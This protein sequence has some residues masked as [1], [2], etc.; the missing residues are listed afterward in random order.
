MR[1]EQF[2]TAVIAV[3]LTTFPEL[4]LL[5]EQATAHMQPL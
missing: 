2:V 5:E 4:Y 3:A 1:H